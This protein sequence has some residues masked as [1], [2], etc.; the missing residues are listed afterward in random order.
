MT[1]TYE[2][3]HAFYLACRAQIL[4]TSKEMAWAERHVVENAAHKWILGRYAEADRANTNRQH[5]AMDNLKFGQ[6][7][8]AHSPLNINH[9]SMIVGAYV[10]SE[11]M[12]PTGEGAD[13]SADLNP[14][15]EALSVFWK[16]YFEDEYVEVE[17][18]HKA[19]Q[20]FYS[21]ECVPREI[22]CAGEAG[23]G[24][25]FEY[26]GRSHATYCDHLNDPRS[27]VIKDLIQP[28]FTAGALI[29]PP[30]K[31]GWSRADIKQ[32]S[33]LA[34]DHADNAERLYSQLADEAPEA[35]ADTWEQ[36]MNQIL[37]DAEASGEMAEWKKKAKKKKADG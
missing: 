10:A 29:V 30:V 14:Y 35:E 25:V 27:G 24:Q 13:E 7:L 22:A 18:A 33:D 17:K 37:L 12:Y 21:M 28:H 2:G 26:A 8:L 34:R 32:I 19:G 9:T 20:L 31:P 3:Q 15:L 11:I 4:D 6:P 5:F 1:A 23:C 36:V 16:H